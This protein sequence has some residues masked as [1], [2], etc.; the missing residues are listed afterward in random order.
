MLSLFNDILIA[1]FIGLY[2]FDLGYVGGDS[3]MYHFGNTPCVAAG[4]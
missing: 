4:L 1:A 3:L 2:R